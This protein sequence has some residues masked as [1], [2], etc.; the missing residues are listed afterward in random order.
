MITTEL[1]E[2]VGGR[3]KAAALCGVSLWATYKWD[4]DGVPSKH[5]RAFADAAGVSLEE[6][7]S[8]APARPKA[9]PEAA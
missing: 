2:K 6:I 8:T 3:D 7:A 1:F 9:S 5:W 4:E